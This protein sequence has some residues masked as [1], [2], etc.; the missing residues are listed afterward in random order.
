MESI[1]GRVQSIGELLAGWGERIVF[2][3]LLLVLVG[4]ALVGVA[5]AIA[6][7]G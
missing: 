6:M 2:V 5:I 3:E 1:C 4:S 7:N